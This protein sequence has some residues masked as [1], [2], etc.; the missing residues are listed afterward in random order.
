MTSSVV[1]VSRGADLVR[2]DRQTLYNHRKKGKLSFVRQSD[3]SFGV[4]TAELQRVYGKLYVTEAE[5]DDSRKIDDDKADSA[6]ITELRHQLE[7][8]E[9]ELKHTKEKVEAWKEKAEK[10]TDSIKLLED[11][12]IDKD[13]KNA[14]AEAKWKQALAA[15]RNEVDQARREA[16]EMRRMGEDRVASIQEES[17][18]KIEA[19]QSRGLLARLLNKIPMEALD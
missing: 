15:R 9:M 1:S 3:G 5:L 11:Q 12:R 16:D 14:E 13:Q 10:A 17:R 4:D 7:L 2:R 8:K 6:T 18:A 19:L